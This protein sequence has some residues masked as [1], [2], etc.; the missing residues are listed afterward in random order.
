[1]LIKPY[2]P[3]EQL[4]ARHGYNQK[5]MSQAMRRKLGSYSPTTLSH[6]LNGQSP[7]PMNEVV[8][9]AE[10]LNIP[11]N[12]MYDYFI[13]PWAVQAKKKSKKTTSAGTLVSFAG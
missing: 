6:R 3:L 5:E 7:F 2:Q 9:M 13:K 4:M 12:E 11:P 10:I 8:A 1:M